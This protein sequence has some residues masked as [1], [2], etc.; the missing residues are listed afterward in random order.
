MS[1]TKKKQRPPA[2]PATPIPEPVV[3]EPVIPEPKRPLRL[4]WRSPAELAENPRNWRTHPESQITALTDV[5]AEVGWAG[6]CLYNETTGR[7]LDGHAR[8]KVALAQGAAE[9]PVL[10]GQWTEEQEIKIL[11]T[12][13][14]LAAEATIDP[15]KLREVL[16]QVQ[17]GSKAIAD[18][19][20]KLAEAGG[21][22]PMDE[23]SQPADE[24]PPESNYSEQYGV[25]CIFENEEQQKE[26]FERLQGMGYKV[27]VV[28]T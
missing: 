1:T 7:L 9:V 22:V 25:I 16:D 8:K 28:V 13:D 26:A 10:V 14:P 15:I 12:L 19:L 20:T 4:E 6:V 11:A 2:E 24:D 3:P 21:V 5:I 23:E 27:R 18:M 17:T